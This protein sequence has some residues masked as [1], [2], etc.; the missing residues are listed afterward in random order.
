MGNH[1]LVNLLGELRDLA[2]GESAAFAAEERPAMRE[3]AFMAWSSRRPSGPDP[4]AARASFGTRFPSGWL[5]RRE[6]FAPGGRCGAW[7]LQRK[8]AVVVGDTLFV[9]GGLSAQFTDWPLERLDGAFAAR[10]AHRLGDIAALEAAGWVDFAPPRE[11]RPELLAVRLATLPP[12]ADMALADAARRVVAWEREPIRGIRRPLWSCGLAL[13]RPVLE[14]NVADAA[15]TRHGVTRIAAAHTVAPRLHPTLRLEGRAL[16]LDT[17][18]LRSVYRGI[19]NAVTFDDGGLAV[20]L[21]DGRRTTPWIDATA[22]LPAAP[23]GDK[24]AFAARLAAT[25]VPAGAPD[26]ARVPVSIGAATLAAVGYPPTRQ[27]TNC[28]ELAA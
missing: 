14:Q 10:L 5:A 3:A 25:P 8:L 7:P 21:E 16:Q 27:G 4:D 19:G 24:A 13:C 2:P 23:G 26:G 15:T 12:D 18:M 6:A 17:G 9:F 28:R 11:S 1:E 20:P 22:V